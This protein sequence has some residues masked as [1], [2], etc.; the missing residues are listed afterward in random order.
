MVFEG[1]DAIEDTIMEM[2]FSKP[3]PEVFWGVQPGPPH[4]D[5]IRE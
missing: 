2:L 3:V 4:S 1:I 5:I